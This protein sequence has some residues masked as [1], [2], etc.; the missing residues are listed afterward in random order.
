MGLKESPLPTQP[1]MMLWLIPLIAWALHG[2][3]ISVREVLLVVSRPLA[4][5][6]LAAGCAFAVQVCCASRFSPLSRLVLEST[7]LL[8]VFLAVLLFV[9]GQKSFYIELFKTMKRTSSSTDECLASA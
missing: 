9:A 2:T 8:V 5:S 1:S 3:V 7:V 6:V 4:S